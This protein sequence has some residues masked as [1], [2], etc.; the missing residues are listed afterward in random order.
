MLL[1]QSCESQSL[2]SHWL[3]L[4]LHDGM[5][6]IDL[7]HLALHFKLLYLDMHRQAVKKKRQNAKAISQINHPFR[8]NE[9]L[10]VL[11]LATPERIGIAGIAGIAGRAGIAGIAGVALAQQRSIAGVA[12]IAG[13]AGI[14]GIAGIAGVAGIAGIA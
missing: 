11:H 12:G 2:Q 4:I 10:L 9:P 6:N 13:R 7:G 14:A 1:S 5:R 8:L 3:R